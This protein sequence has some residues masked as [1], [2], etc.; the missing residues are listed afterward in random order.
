MSLDF[1]RIPA[2]IE[3]EAVRYAEAQ[4][5]TA[6]EALVE[7]FTKG[8]TVTR[9]LKTRSVPPITDD[10]LN[11]IDEAFPGLSAMDDVTEE[12]WGRIDARIR[13]MKSEGLST[14]G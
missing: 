6:E 3:L 12:Q 4:H 7:I 8:L 5:I 1:T 13:R 10:E 11:Q 2:S 14:R 9:K